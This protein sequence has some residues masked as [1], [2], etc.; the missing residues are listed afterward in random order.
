MDT[1]I[2]STTAPVLQI[3][4]SAMAAGL[5]SNA[6]CQGIAVDGAGHLYLA[7]DDVILTAPY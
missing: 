1:I 6:V 4:G 3:G 7:A 5:P 2:G